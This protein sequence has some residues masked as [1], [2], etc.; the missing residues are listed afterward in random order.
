MMIVVLAAL[1]MTGNSVSVGSIPPGSMPCG[2]NPEQTYVHNHTN[3]V[4]DSET[5]RVGS[6]QPGDPDNWCDEYC[7]KTAGCKYWTTDEPKRQA[8]WA[9][10][11]CT[12]PNRAYPG[13]SS[14]LP[15]PPPPPTEPDAKPNSTCNS[16]KVF[17]PL[18][19]GIPDADGT[20]LPTA[21]CQNAGKV[22]SDWTTTAYLGMSCQTCRKFSTYQWNIR[23][24][25]LDERYKFLTSTIESRN[26]AGQIV[27]NKGAALPADD[28]TLS[29]WF[30][31]EFT[32]GWPNPSWGWQSEFD[33]L[34]EAAYLDDAGNGFGGGEDWKVIGTAG[35]EEGITPT[36]T[37]YR[38]MPGNLS[39]GD[40]MDKGVDCPKGNFLELNGYYG[41]PGR[42]ILTKLSTRVGRE[43]WYWRSCMCNSTQD[44]DAQVPFYYYVVQGCG[45]GYPSCISN[46]R[47]GQLGYGQNWLQDTRIAYSNLF[48][49]WAK[50]PPCSGECIIMA[51]GSSVWTTYGTAIPTN[52][53][54]LVQLRAFASFNPHALPDACGNKGVMLR[55]AGMAIETDGTVTCSFPCPTQRKLPANWRDIA[56]AKTDEDFWQM[57]ADANLVN[58]RTH[59]TVGSCPNSYDAKQP[60]WNMTRC[61][62]GDKQVNQTQCRPRR[63]I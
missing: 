23:G 11:A 28:D 10:R 35:Q 29:C 43:V 2:P 22:Q 48:D 20:V 24:S 37:A 17:W 59:A 19:D 56:S 44:A 63:H 1:V 7:N 13:W 38:W 57:V 5:I 47:P 60:N 45:S 12:N 42:V 50:N 27:Y 14:C 18:R 41:H 3:C 53:G 21:Q 61:Q 52:L 6:R 31:P 49:I 40:P 9:K 30:R 16:A 46:P 51:G 58:P 15:P 39:S 33:V 8:C 36:L 25:S 34:P 55:F 4:N 26:G 54:I 32:W 62:P